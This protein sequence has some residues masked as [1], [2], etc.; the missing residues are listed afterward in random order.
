MI[1]KKIEFAC[2]YCHDDGMKYKI[3]TTC[4]T[5]LFI[6]SATV[7]FATDVYITIDEN[8]NRIFSDTPSKDARTHRVKEMSTM[9]AITLPKK[10]T[11]TPLAESDSPHI[12]QHVRI[13]SP[14]AESHLNRSKLGNFIVTAEVLPLLHEK[15][16]AVLLLDGKELSSGNQ[17]SWQVH[18]ANRGSHQLQVIIRQHNNKQKRISSEIQSIYVQR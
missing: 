16:E 1:I 10:T 3:I 8:G 11:A 4:F 6:G 15:D 2:L 14:Q 17:L 13:T 5:A 7:C 12:Y 9:P 18:N